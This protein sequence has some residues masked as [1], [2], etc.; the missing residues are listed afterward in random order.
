M[1]QRFAQ[2]LANDP[3]LRRKV[4]GGAATAAAIPIPGY[5]FAA[6]ADPHYPP[7]SVSPGV[8]SQPTWIKAG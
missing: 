6:N 5:A 7:L 8:E 4:A 1:A 3:S 2:R